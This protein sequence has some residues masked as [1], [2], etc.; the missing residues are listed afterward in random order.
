MANKGPAN[1][2]KLREGLREFELELSSLK[3]EVD[4]EIEN[5]LRVSHG[6]EYLQEVLKKVVIA[7]EAVCLKTVTKKNTPLELKKRE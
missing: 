3:T 6:I 5:M 4:K 7:C 1:A 2:S